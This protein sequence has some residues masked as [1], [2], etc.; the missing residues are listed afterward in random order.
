MPLALV[1]TEWI[2]GNLVFYD[3]NGDEIFTIDGVNRK[4][5]FNSA[6]GLDA[7]VAIEATDIATG[8]V[9]ATK[10]GAGAAIAQ[11][12]GLEVINKTGSDIV[13]DK[14]VAVSGLDVT[15]GK[16][17]IVLA[18]ADVAAHEDVWVTTATIANNAAGVV[19]KAALSAANLNTNA[20]GTAG[21]P[22][23]LDVTAGGF[24]VTAPTGA[25]A[26]VH[27]VGMV[28]VKS[29]TVG[30]IFW[31]CSRVRKLGTNELQALAITTALL[32]AGL[33]VIHHI[34]PEQAGGLDKDVVVT[35]KIRVLDVIVVNAAAGGA[36]DTITVKNGATAITDAIDTN[37]GDKAVTRAGTID[38]AQATIAAAG[39]LRVT[40]A[41]GTN[42]ANCNVFV[43]AMRVV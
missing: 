20:V 3:K 27:P 6:A 37:K 25:T 17:K 7:P 15:S 38:A 2:N 5:S 42:D 29:A 4:V 40:K 32:A 35:H 21:D 13:T 12:I 33:M 39:T 11:K 26:R 41:D 16:P 8:A 36:N 31:L 30:Q 9:T 43:I 10:L 1:R 22:V 34:L 24:T 18:D 23:Y 19:V 28:V 14:L